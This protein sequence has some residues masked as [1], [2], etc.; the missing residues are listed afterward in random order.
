MKSDILVEFQGRQIDT[1]AQLNKLKEIWKEQGGKVK[2]L[3]D[4][5]LYINVEQGL[6]YYVINGD[7][8]NTNSFEIV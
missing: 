4:V 5:K 6:V 3:D 8:A 1:N 7:V 2:D